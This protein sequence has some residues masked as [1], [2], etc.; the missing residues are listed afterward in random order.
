[1]VKEINYIISSNIDMLDT[2]YLAVGGSKQLNINVK[3][4]SENVEMISSDNNIVT[5]ENGL[6]KGIGNGN[7][8]IT[9]KLI[10]NEIKTFNIVV[11]DLIVPMSFNNDKDYLPC[12]RY[13]EEE[14]NLLDNILFSRVKEAGDGT[15][16]GVVA[17]IRFILL[18]F[19]YTIKYFNENGRL[20]DNGMT[21]HIDGEGRYY[22]KGLYLNKS[23]F[24][25]LESGAHTASGPQIWGC[26][27]YDSFLGEYRPNGFTCSGFISWA[28]Y[29]GGLDT[30]DVGAGDYTFLNNDLSDLGPHQQITYDF[31]K[32]GTYKAGDF[33][34]RDGHAALILGISDDT[35][36]T[37]ESLPPKV[38]VYVY[39]RYNGIVKD[40]NLT[41]II[42]MTNIYPNGEGSYTNM[43]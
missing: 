5:I 37:A 43:W 21:S 10:N 12:E 28:L 25:S 33:I 16:G 4:Y 34:A 17:T 3:N 8:T 11:T 39:D 31:M 23:K 29:N 20:V 41:Y 32:N 22:H 9:I 14:A 19:P 40:P 30:G 18:E 35:I 24:A 7:A 36:Y 15:R 6:I 26:K 1:L 38:K 13:T 27:L 42:D 2:Y